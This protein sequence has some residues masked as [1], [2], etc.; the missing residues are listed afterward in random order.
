[1]KVYDTK[2]AAAGVPY[3]FGVVQIDHKGLYNRKR[4]QRVPL[5]T[6]P[7]DQ[8]VTPQ[9]KVTTQMYIPKSGVANW[10][11]KVGS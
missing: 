1:M 9:L 10:L 4:Y 3:F 6:D 2:A 7:L 11:N 8:I 5:G